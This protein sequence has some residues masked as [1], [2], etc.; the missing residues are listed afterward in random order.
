MIDDK[1]G[2]YWDAYQVSKQGLTAMA[3]LLAREYAGSS[4]RINCYNPG[5]TRT[6][7]QVRAYPAADDNDRLPSPQEHV[8]AFLYLMSDDCDENGEIFTPPD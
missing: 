3:G 2:A 8:D 5:K 1:T 4:L 6:S 7:L